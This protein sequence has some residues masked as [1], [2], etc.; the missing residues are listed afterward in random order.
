MAAPK[1][2]AAWQYKV[3]SDNKIRPAL[4][5]GRHAGHGTYFAAQTEKGDLL[6][7]TNNRP[8]PYKDL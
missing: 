3:L 1:S 4:Y 8:I 6:R 2:K 5:N 7:D